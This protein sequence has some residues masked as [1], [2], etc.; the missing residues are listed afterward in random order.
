MGAS[1][2]DAFLAHGDARGVDAWIAVGMLIDFS[3]DPRQPVLDVLAERDFPEALA[4]GK[5]RSGR[6]PSD[7]C[8]KSLLISGTDHYFESAAAPLAAASEEFLSRVF[9]GACARP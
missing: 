2:V 6:L 4:S 1:M 8:S 3:R 5:L 7:R 9:E